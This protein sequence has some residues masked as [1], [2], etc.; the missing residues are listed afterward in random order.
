MSEPTLSAIEMEHRVW[1]LVKAGDMQA[2]ASA[3][4][5]LNS[6]YPDHDS[7]WITSSRVAISLNQP[8][9]AL[10]AAEKALEITPD[11][12]EWLLQKMASLALAGF[13]KA[14]RQLGDQFA[15]HEFETTFHTA[16][17]AVLMRQVGNQEAS[18]FQYRRAIELEPDNPNH[19]FNLATSLRGMGKAADAAAHLDRALELNP[20]DCEAQLIRS[21][22]RTQTADKNNVTSLKKALATVPEDAPGRVQLLYA[23]SKELDDLGDIAASFEALTEGAAVRRAALDY[24]IE[25]D[26]QQMQDIRDNFDTTFFIEVAE[27]H[28]S[29][30]PIFVMGLPR[31][32]ATLVE[33]LLANHSVVS[34][35]GEAQAF[36]NAMIRL[37]REKHGKPFTDRRDFLPVA[38]TIDFA[39]LGADYDKAISEQGESAHLVDKLPANFLYAGL[40]HRA[41][42]KASLIVVER[43]PLD[44]CLAMFKTLFPRMYPYTYDLEELGKYYLSYRSMMDHWRNVLGEKLLVVKYEDLIENPKDTVEAVLEH[45]NLSFEEDCLQFHA[46]ANRTTKPSA[47]KVKRELLAKSVGIAENYREQLRP[48]ADRIAEAGVVEA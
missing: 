5:E 37:C 30:K 11:K 2:A 9:I 41:L 31:S 22:L 34:S 29:A 23:L 24:N 47:L 46:A 6:A 39:Q 1:Q 26:L 13:T 35:I 40:I 15:Y 44:A 10:Q 28:T 16:T 27:G 17:C 4:D 25:D 7:G 21:G 20:A 3:C 42:P 12:P 48:L 38:R 43:D 32:G 33:Q 45:C 14:A 19:H 36:G 18:V 8:G